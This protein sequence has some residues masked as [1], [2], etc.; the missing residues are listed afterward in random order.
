[1]LEQRDV[2]FATCDRCGLR[3]DAARRVYV[4]VVPVD[5]Q[6][7]DRGVDASGAARDGAQAPRPERV[8][9]AQDALSGR[10]DRAAGR[11]ALAVVGV[12]DLPDSCASARSPDTLVSYAANPLITVLEAFI[13]AVFVCG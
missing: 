11:A 6:L 13:C 2:R 10:P 9:G 1:M 12:A 3:A 5:N 7:A 4:V 8:E